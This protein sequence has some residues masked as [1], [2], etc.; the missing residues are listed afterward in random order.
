MLRRALKNF[1]RGVAEG[2][3][4]KPVAGGGA[5]DPPKVRSQKKGARA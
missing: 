4:G 3:G 5:F 1:A 2:S